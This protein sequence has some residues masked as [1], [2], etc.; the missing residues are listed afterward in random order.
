MDSALEMGKVSVHLFLRA[1]ADFEVFHSVE[2]LRTRLRCSHH[3]CYQLKGDYAFTRTVWSSA[4]V[5][6]DARD[7]GTRNISVL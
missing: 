1:K 4:E 2:Y 7:M 3:V 6:Q 5:L